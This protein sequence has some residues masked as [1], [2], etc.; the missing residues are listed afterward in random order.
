MKGVVIVIKT[1]KRN[2]IQR[3]FNYHAELCSYYLDKMRESVEEKNFKKADMYYELFNKHFLKEQ[4]ASLK[5][6]EMAF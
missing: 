3:Q 2:I 4:I 1:I 5:Y 6:M